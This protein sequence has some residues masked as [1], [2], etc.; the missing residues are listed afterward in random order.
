[1]RAATT[2]A[3]TLA[4]TLTLTLGLTVTL[5]LIKTEYWDRVCGVGNIIY[6]WRATPMRHTL[7]A[8]D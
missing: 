2:L 5:T 8:V 4:L 6:E 1:M 3:L 7:K